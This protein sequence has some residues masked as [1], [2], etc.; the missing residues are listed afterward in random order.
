MKSIVVY[1]DGTGQDGG[2]RPEQRISNIYKLYWTSRNHPGNAIEPH[3]QVAFYDAGLGTD[4]G[5]TAITAPVRFVEKNAA[6]DKAEF[7]AKAAAKPA[8]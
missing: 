1:S 7:A 5:A 4:I 3:E 6:A 8:E 2:V